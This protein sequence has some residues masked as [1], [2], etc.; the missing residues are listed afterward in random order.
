MAARRFPVRIGRSPKSDIQLDDPAVWDE[1]LEVS[2]GV[3]HDFVAATQSNA[4]ATINGTAFT[5][6]TAIRNGDVIGIGA[7]K[8]QF[9]LADPG[10]RGL[11]FRECLTWI[12]IVVICMI[13]VALIYWLLST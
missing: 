13:Q 11:A 3:T 5:E 10:Q 12:G 8:I 9:W 2:L 1:H 6:P 4:L 7:A